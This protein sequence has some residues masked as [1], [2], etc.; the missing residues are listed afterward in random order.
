MII[1]ESREDT[2]NPEKINK[3]ID[4]VQKNLQGSIETSVGSIREINEVVSDQYDIGD[5]KLLVENSDSNKRIV[6]SLNGENYYVNLTK[7]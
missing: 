6:L 5:G 7:V 1:F 4:S 3:A 2:N